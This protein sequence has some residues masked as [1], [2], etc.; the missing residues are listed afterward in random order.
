MQPL[1]PVISY[2]MP[3]RLPVLLSGCGFFALCGLLGV[4]ASVDNNTL[5]YKDKVFPLPCNEPVESHTVATIDDMDLIK[6]Y[7]MDLGWT[8]SEW[9][10]IVTGK[11]IGRAHV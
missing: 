4:R 8:P 2:L 9:K 3:V 6:Q 10:D 11:Q 1:S 7:L 5:V